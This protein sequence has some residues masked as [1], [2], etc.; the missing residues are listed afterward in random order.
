MTRLPSCRVVQLS[1]LLSASSASH[2]R[3]WWNFKVVSERSGREGTVGWR[4]GVELPRQYSGDVFNASRSYQKS[5]SRIGIGRQRSR[6]SR[7]RLYLALSERK[8]SYY[9][10]WVQFLQQAA[11]SYGAGTQD[12]LFGMFTG[13]NKPRPRCCERSRRFKSGRAHVDHQ[14]LVIGCEVPGHENANGPS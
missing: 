3:E 2:S 4:S 11:W 14:S 7:P 6:P 10:R 5:T 9:A 8:A 12:L 13:L 1:D